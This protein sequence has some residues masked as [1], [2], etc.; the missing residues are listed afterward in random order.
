[1]KKCSV[2]GAGKIENYSQI[3]IDDNDYII[4][5]DGGFVHTDKLGLSPDVIVGD[6]DTL[7]INTDVKCEVIEYSPEKDDTDTMLAVKLAV[8]RG[9]NNIDIYGGLG[10]RL[11]HSIANIQTLLFLKDKGINANLVGDTDFVTVIKNEEKSFNKKEG[12]YFS[13]FSFTEECVGVTENGVKY[14]LNNYLL[15][16]SFPLGVSN[17][18]IDDFCTV[19]VEKGILVIVFSKK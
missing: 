8:E 6:F 2:F 11:D 5:A 4:C 19:K 1:M 9:Y 3:N 12:Y 18:I 10:G 14:P 17:E 15:T 7:K 13:V 16:S